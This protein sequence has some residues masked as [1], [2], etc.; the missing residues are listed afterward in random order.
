MPCPRPI[1]SR[2]HHRAH[3]HREFARAWA[4]RGDD[5]RALEQAWLALDLFRALDQPVWQAR[6]VWQEARELFRQQGLDPAGRGG[7]GAAR[8]ARPPGS[9]VTA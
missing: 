8:R 4:L 6:A 9:G 1:R 7:A 3:T 2:R 5:R